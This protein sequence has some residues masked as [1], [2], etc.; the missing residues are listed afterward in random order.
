MGIPWVQNIQCLKITA[1]PLVP[2]DHSEVQNTVYGQAF[3]VTSLHHQFPLIFS[4]WRSFYE[5]WQKT[6]DWTEP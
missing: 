2:V 5:D 3:Q 4:A 6:G 1:A